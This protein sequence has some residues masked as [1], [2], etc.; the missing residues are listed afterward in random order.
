MIRIRRAKALEVAEKRPGLL[1]VAVEVDGMRSCAL[2]YV[3]LCGP[4]SPG[5][6]LVLNTTAI[7]LGLGTGGV[8]FVI[9][10]E[11]GADVD[12]APGGHAMKLRYTPMQVQVPVV[13][14]V[15]PDALD[16]VV[17]L[18]GMPVVAAGLHSAL[19]PVA[20]GVRATSPNARVAVIVTDG[21]ALPLAFSDT[22]PALRSAGLVQSTITCGQAFGGEIEAVNKFSALIAARA[23]ASSDVTVVVMGPGNLGT[24]TRYGFA[25][26][27]VAEIIN[28]AVALGAKAIVV[29]RIS[30]AD[31]RERHQG[32]SHHTLTALATALAPAT[33]PLPLLSADRAEIVRTQLVGH[34]GRHRILEVELGNVE[35]ALAKSPVRLE[36]MGRSFTD[37]PDAFR[38]AAAAGIL[39][40]RLAGG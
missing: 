21:G 12:P 27:E 24:A 35:E 36:S 28:A 29:P 23:V 4:I 39:A 6:M 34:E 31:K 37:D 32:V 25:L 18:A 3:D 10:V 40:G 33:V 15:A 8:H 13:E 16:A 7:A 14:E 30:F 17:S 26:M 2:A 38:A 22:I 19:T 9:A 5:D 1:Q 11:R 20:I